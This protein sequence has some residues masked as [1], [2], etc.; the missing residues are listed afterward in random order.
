MK[1]ETLLVT[2]AMLNAQYELSSHDVLD[3]LLPFVKF[4]I[5][6]KVSLNS[7]I[8]LSQLS[9]SLSEDF[10][11]INFPEHSCKILL[12]RLSKTDLVTKSQRRYYR[13]SPTTKELEEFKKSRQLFNEKCRCIGED[14]ANYLNNSIYH[15]ITKEDAL[16]FLYKFFENHGIDLYRSSSSMSYI[17][18]SSSFLNRNIEYETAQYIINLEKQNSEYF[19]VLQ[20]I[21]QGFFISSSIYFQLSHTDNPAA[22][23]ENT[24]CYLDSPLI[25]DFLKYKTKEAESATSQLIEM[26]KNK[27]GTICVFDHTVDEVK[28]IL[29]AYRLSIQYPNRVN[30]FHT[31]EGLDARRST[32]KDVENEKTTLENTLKNRGIHIIETPKFDLSFSKKREKFARY[33]QEKIHYLRKETLNADVNS[34]CSVALLRGRARATSLEKCGHVFITSNPTLSEKTNKYY[35]E[36]YGGNVQYIFPESLFSAL[37]WIKSSEDY[38]NYPKIKLLQTAASALTFTCEMNEEFNRQLDIL[39]EKGDLTHNDVILLQSD[40]FVQNELMSKTRGNPNNISREKIIDIKNSYQ[41]R[42]IEDQDLYW[43]AKHDDLKKEQEE[44]KSLSTRLSKENNQ[45]K[46]QKRLLE[47]EKSKKSEEISAYIESESKKTYSRV[48]WF[49]IIFFRVFLGIPGLLA[50]IKTILNVESIW[51]FSN[52]L[53]LAISIGGIVDFF[54]PKLKKV[55]VFSEFLARKFQQKRKENLKKSLK[56]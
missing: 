13:S 19:D 46:E 44:T 30:S 11:F 45:L 47:N 8:K 3:S 16:E 40:H 38:S 42:V 37:L 24:K 55:M 14:F 15:E 49:S 53:M 9:L 27:K 56:N 39:E 4:F 12:N 6:D 51:D 5:E 22:N 2:S 21:L 26:I 34:I 23:F 35:K 17:S 48:K 52:I 41:K 31:L 18:E 7:E 54:C 43:K 1:R 50:V 32:P 36:S 20:E 33:L 29:D 28:R 25:L 10:N